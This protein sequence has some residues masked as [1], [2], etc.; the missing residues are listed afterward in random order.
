M[1]PRSQVINRRALSF[2]FDLPA[3]Q[4]AGVQIHPPS[5][6]N[7]PIVVQHGQVKPRLKWAPEHTKYLYELME[8]A[9]LTLNRPLKPQDFPAITEALHRKFQG[10]INVNIPYLER[11]YHTIHSYATRKQPYDELVR[12]VL[13]D[14]CK[15]RAQWTPRN[16]Q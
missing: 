2:L 5:R 11:G 10:T 3:N 9:M 15:N 13:P 12:R 4:R 6:F 14:Q 7:P 16:H 1:P 8:L